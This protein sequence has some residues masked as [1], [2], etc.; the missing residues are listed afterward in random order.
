MRK[1]IFPEFQEEVLTDYDNDKVAIIILNQ[2]PFLVKKCIEHI[3]ANTAVL[4]EILIGCTDDIS[5]YET[6]F[7]DCQVFDLGKWHY[8]KNNN[9]LAKQTDANTLIFMNDDVFVL[10]GWLEPILEALSSKENI[11]QVGIKLLFP[12]ERIQHAGVVFRKDKSDQPVHYMIGAHKNNPEV[13]ATRTFAAVTGACIGMRH[14]LFDAIG[15]FA[16]SYNVELG[17]VDLSIK[18]WAYGKQVVYLPNSVAYHLTAESRGPTGEYRIFAEDRINLMKRCG[19]IAKEM[20]F[21]G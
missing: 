1:D 2:D 11:G 3:K 19:V 7:E 10:K 18:V 21:L 12:N 14:S 8:S 5:L 15:G 6:G 17:D 20:G 9:F 4:P 13:N 16:N